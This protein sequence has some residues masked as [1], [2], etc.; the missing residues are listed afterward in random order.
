[1]E[2]W[3]SL[4]RKFLEW[5]WFSDK[6]MIVLFI[7]LLL[8]ANHSSK[9]WQGIDIN[10]GELITSINKLAHAINVSEQNIRTCLKRLEKTGEINKQST[11]KLTKITICNYDSYQD[12]QQASNKQ[13]NKRVTNK[14]QAT[15]KQLTTNNNDNKEIK[16]LYTE[17][18][19]FASEFGKELVR[20]FYDYWSE[21]NKKGKQRWELEKTWDTKRRLSRWN[22]NNFGDK[23]ETV[24]FIGTYKTLTHKEKADFNVNPIYDYVHYKKERKK[25]FTDDKGKYIENGRERVYL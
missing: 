4:H 1:M 19:P 24:S 23:V 7:Y 11:S 20:D 13:T 6:N 14:Q 8:K 17:L 25:V 16:D 3:I 18:I 22:K 12:K 21:E 9:K 5:Q 2:G 10:R 15:N